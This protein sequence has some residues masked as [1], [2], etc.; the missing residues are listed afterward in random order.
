M[1]RRSRPRPMDESGMAA[2]EMEIRANERRLR[3]VQ[4]ACQNARSRRKML[5]DTLARFDEMSPEGFRAW[6]SDEI[7]QL[8]GTLDDVPGLRLLTLSALARRL[9]LTQAAVVRFR[10]EGMPSVRIGA[11]VR[12]NIENVMTWLDNQ[13]SGDSAAE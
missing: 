8:G 4:V 10:A 6:L 13:Y 11:N 5:E 1:V 2:R 9:S 3:S 12:Y 7:A